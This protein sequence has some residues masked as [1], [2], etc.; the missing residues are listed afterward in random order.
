MK[1][2]KSFLFYPFI[3]QT[4]SL[5]CISPFK[6]TTYVVHE[7]VKRGLEGHRL[8]ELLPGW[9]KVSQ[10]TPLSPPPRFTLIYGQGGVGF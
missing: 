9:E 5:H 4:H 8:M 6:W 7:L 3:V 2:I 1:T 10:A